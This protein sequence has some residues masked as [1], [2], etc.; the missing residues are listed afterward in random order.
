MGISV[1]DNEL[2]KYNYSA[3][4]MNKIF[5]EKNL[6]QKWLDVEAAL[7]AAE[8]KAGLIP[9]DVAAIIREKA[10]VENID[11]EIIKQQ[12]IITGHPFMPLLRAF[13]PICG[14]AGEYVHLGTTTQDMMDTAEILQIRE[15]YELILKQLKELYEEL[16]KKAEEKKKTII[17]GRTNGQHALP[18]TVGFKFAVWAS[19]TKRHLQRLES[20]KDR[21][22]IGQFSGAVGS[23]A[24]LGKDAVQVRKFF[25]EELN[26]NSPDI[27]WNTSRDNV[28]E[29]ASIL[30]IMASTLSKI[31]N[32][33]YALQ[34]QE[35][36]EF[37]EFTGH[38][39]VG[40]STM[41]H[42]K[43]PFISMQIVSLGRLIKTAVAEAFETLENEHE[44]D[45]RSLSVEWDYVPRVF[46][47][48]S[49]AL[50]KSINLVSNLVIKE[51]NINRNINILQGLV[52]SEKI[53]MKLSS[54]IGRQTAH[55]LMHE[56]ALEALENDISLK[57][58]IVG[59]KEIMEHFTKEE[60]EESLKPENYLGLSEYFVDEVLAKR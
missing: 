32:E 24:S 58:M 46:C 56:L 6:L 4:D 30:G 15:G 59:N 18:I 10:K 38:G 3:D 13:T 57:D 49:A 17:M 47:F 5:D 51:K 26:L 36:S 37:E 60:V 55:D 9:D 35:F 41:P 42:K 19:E 22:F 33:V 29:I 1:F 39:A 44:R 50:E 43:N 20:C 2:Y 48:A 52:F 12:A 40:S 27:T 54:T 28:V 7:A 16:L 14:S 25:F 53:M 23:L 45:P 11:M 31:G 34:K 21:L 8:A